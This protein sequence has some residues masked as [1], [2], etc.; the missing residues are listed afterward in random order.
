MAIEVN[1][2]RGGEVVLTTEQE[3]DEFLDRVRTEA[4]PPQ[5][6][7]YVSIQGDTYGQLL[8]IGVH[9]DRGWLGYGKGPDA[10]W[11]RGSDADGDVFY[12]FQRT[13]TVEVPA[14]AEIPYD[15]VRAAVKEFLTTGGERP[16]NVE[17]IEE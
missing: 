4:D 3:V 7:A 8:Q 5:L 11:S 12:Y 1:F 10:W 15:A 6:M 13:Q 16:T 2:Q 9:G 14:S 17:W